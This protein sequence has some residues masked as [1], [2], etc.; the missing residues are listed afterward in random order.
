[1]KDVIDTVDISELEPL[2]EDFFRA[3]QRGKHLEGYR[4]LGGYYLISMDGTGYFSSV[5]T[6]SSHLYRK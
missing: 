2:F 6:A 4:F 5:F 3:V 1:M